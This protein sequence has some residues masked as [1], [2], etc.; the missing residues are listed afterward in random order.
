ML[1]EKMA[2]MINFAVLKLYHKLIKPNYCVLKSPLIIR[3]KQKGFFL[4]FTFHS[5][6][7]VKKSITY[8]I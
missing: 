7:Y 6:Y 3:I 5:H 8:I 4:T 1:Y 2:R